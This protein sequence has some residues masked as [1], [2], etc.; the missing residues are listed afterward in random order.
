MYRRGGILKY[1]LIGAVLIV[2]LIA[3]I[4][5]MLPE[6]IDEHAGQ[7]YINDGFDMVWMTPYEGVPVSE[8]NTS[9][10]QTVNSL[11][12]Y[13]GSDYDTRIGI[14]TSEHQWEVN[15]DA[16]ATMIDFAIIR[17]GYRGYTEGGLFLDPWFDTNLSGA[18][19]AG[20]ETGVYFFSQATNVSEAIEEAEFVLDHLAGYRITLPVFFDWEKIDG[21]GARTDEISQQTMTD[22]ALAFCRTIRNAGYDAGVYFNRTLGYYGFDLSRL[23]GNSFWVSVPGNY[24]DFYY[25]CDYWQFTF[26]ASIP[27]VS[28]AAD[29]SMRFI[30]RVTSETNS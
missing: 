2:V 15:W 26:T 24:P 10:F 18:I 30:P 23:I 11:P 4:R 6:H 29:L 13:M 7:V 20:L 9:D 14:D 5:M 17:L 16:A 1:F 25:A 19:N 27:G 3:L 28:G 8:L 22:C 21:G 12:I